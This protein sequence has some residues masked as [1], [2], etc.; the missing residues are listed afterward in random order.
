[1]ET[2]P[3][4]TRHR[5]LKMERWFRANAGRFSPAD[6]VF[7]RHGFDIAETATDADT[8]AQM[9][10]DGLQYTERAAEPQTAA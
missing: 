4:H 6:Q 10:R 5:L 8:L 7:I 1:M 2:T 3:R 9:L